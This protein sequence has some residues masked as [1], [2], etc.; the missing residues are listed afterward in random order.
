MRAKGAVV[1]ASR[2]VARAPESLADVQRRGTWAEDSAKVP[3]AEILQTNEATCRAERGK[4][5]NAG[6]T[7]RME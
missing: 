3:D 4:Q 1:P 5:N 2:A 7:L 6:D